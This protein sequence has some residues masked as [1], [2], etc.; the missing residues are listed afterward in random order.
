MKFQNAVRFMFRKDSE[1]MKRWRSYETG[2]NNK[3]EV[4]ST[5]VRYSDSWVFF[6]LFAVY[7]HCKDLL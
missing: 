5:S 4:P 2:N 3:Y 7:F 1:I 6:L